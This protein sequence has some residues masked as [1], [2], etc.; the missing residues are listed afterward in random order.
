MSEVNC[1]QIDRIGISYT[2]LKYN[3]SDDTYL[4]VSIITE[5]AHKSVKNL[6]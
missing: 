4:F 1:Q 3:G 2:F 6:D 5:T